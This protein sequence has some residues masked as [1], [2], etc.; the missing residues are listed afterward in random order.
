MTEEIQ[1]SLKDLKEMNERIVASSKTIAEHVAYIEHLESRI[2][3]LKKAANGLLEL[4]K[5]KN[6][7]LEED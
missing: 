3:S 2:A 1:V 4:L 5:D 6:F 7:S